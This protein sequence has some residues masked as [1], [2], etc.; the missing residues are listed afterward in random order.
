VEEVLF[1]E[2]L[3]RVRERERA[4]AAAVDVPPLSSETVASLQPP[5]ALLLR[6]M[7][8]ADEGVVW[9]PTAAGLAHRRFAAQPSSWPTALRASRRPMSRRTRMTRP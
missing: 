4:E 3:E 6:L 7:L 1:R 8:D 5:L 2:E 9:P